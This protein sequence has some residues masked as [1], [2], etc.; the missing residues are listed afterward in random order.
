MRQ[1]GRGFEKVTEIADM[2]ADVVRLNSAG[3]ACNERNA[4]AALGQVAF[5][6]AER[7]GNFEHGRM[8]IAF[9]VGSVV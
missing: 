1:L 5:H 7:S 2:F 6:S 9:F 3:P 8:M 4:N